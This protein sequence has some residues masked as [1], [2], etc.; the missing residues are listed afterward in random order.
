MS[1]FI[2]ED[3]AEKFAGMT[4]DE[5]EEILRREE[6]TPLF[7]GINNPNHD[8]FV[9]PTQ[10]GA[11]KDDQWNG[12]IGDA[13]MEHI[14]NQRHKMLEMEH[15]IYTP[16]GN[17]FRTE[18]NVSPPDEDGQRNLN[19]QIVKVMTADSR[20]GHGKY[21]TPEDKENVI[22]FLKQEIEDAKAARIDKQDALD[23]TLV[24]FEDWE[25]MPQLTN[26]IEIP[27]TPPVM[28]IYAGNASQMFYDFIPEDHPDLRKINSFI[29]MVNAIDWDHFSEKTVK[30]FR[31]WIFDQEWVIYTVGERLAQLCEEIEASQNVSPVT[32]AEQAFRDIENDWAKQVSKEVLTKFGEDPVVQELREFE[33]RLIE[34]MKAG[35]LSWA[36]LGKFGQSLYRKYGS[37]MSTSH[38][39]I[40]KDLKKKYAPEVKIGKYDI[41]RANLT[42]LR[43]IFKA[44][45]K[46]E[47]DKLWN[48]DISDEKFEFENA[49]IQVKVDNLAKWVYFNRPFMSLEDLAT[50]GKITID[51]IGFTDRT[52]VLIGLVKKAYRESIAFKSTAPLG[53]MAQ[54][55]I[56]YQRTKANMC[57][58]QEWYSIWQAY[59]VAKQHVQTVLNLPNGKK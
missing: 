31:Q 42:E 24:P 51:D 20:S 40:Y 26:S 56:N 1:E 4:D 6:F 2:L 32:L 23:Q 35:K 8:I 41:N 59:R 15:F 58:E 17:I 55:I 28:Y 33:G 12:S 9:V 30:Y 39:Q 54:Q 27:S 5:N 13:T 45:F 52:V 57:T 50:A 34:N 10:D 22:A 48:S 18:F 21:C 44:R 7:E 37:R 14:W 47:S 53:R 36:E 3:G 19:R 11:D 16:N 49:K 25:H 46:A 38:W 29:S 43:S